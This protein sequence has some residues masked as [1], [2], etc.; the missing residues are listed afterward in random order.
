LNSWLE[1]FAAVEHVEIIDYH[2]VLTNTEAMHYADGLTVDGVHPDMKGFSLM[3]P[4]V[5]VAVQ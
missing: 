1:A 3:E 2:S 4:L 5:S